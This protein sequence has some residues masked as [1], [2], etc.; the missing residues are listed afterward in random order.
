MT[1]FPLLKFLILAFE[2]KQQILPSFL[3]ENSSTHFKTTES[4]I[5]VACTRRKTDFIRKVAK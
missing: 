2:P 1:I 4:Q 5:L 3:A